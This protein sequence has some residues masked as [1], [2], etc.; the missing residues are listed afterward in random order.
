MHRHA[1][2]APASV[3]VAWRDGSLA[4]QIR[5]TGHRAPSAAT[6]DE[7]RGHARAREA[8]TAA[9]SAPAACPAAATRSTARL[10][11]VSGSRS[12]WRTGPE[13]VEAACAARRRGR[14]AIAVNTR[15]RAREVQD[16]L[17]RSR[18]HRD[19]RLARAARRARR[20]STRRARAC[21]APGELSADGPDRSDPD[22]PWMV[23]TSSG[24]TGAPEARRPHPGRHRRPRRARSRTPSA[25]A[26]RT[27][28]CCACCRCAACSASARW[29]A[30]WPRGAPYVLLDGVRRRA[31]RAS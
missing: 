10:P 7:L 4:L 31:R 20:R 16:I 30:R 3:R 11:L 27:P 19:R 29:P 18:G 17:R 5:D 24:T 1:G 28:S 22:A 9:S 2:G 21:S 13:W 25:T 26:R 6:D 15:F 8:P 12:G 23:F 14:A